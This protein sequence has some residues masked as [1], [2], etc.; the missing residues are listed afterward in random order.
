MESTVQLIS[1]GN[2]FFTLDPFRARDAPQE[3]EMRDDD[4]PTYVISPD[5]LDEIR[6]QKMYPFFD[7]GGND[8]N[9]DFQVK[10][11]DGLR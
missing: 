11:L 10:I 2:I 1:I 8:G 4:Q 5:R 7:R 9:G 3:W 6:G